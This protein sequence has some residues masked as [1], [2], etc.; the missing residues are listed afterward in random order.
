MKLFKAHKF[1]SGVL[2]LSLGLGLISSNAYADSQNAPLPLEGYELDVG[3]SPAPPF[4]MIDSHFQDLAGI[5]V[6]IIRELQRR[7]GFKLKNNRFHIMGFGDLLDLAAKGKMDISGAGISLSAKR[8]KIFTQSPATFRSHSVVV[9]PTSSTI[10]GR[11]DLPGKTLAAENGTDATDLVS[12]DMAAL[13]D[14]KHEATTF[15]T[16]Y[17]VAAGH[18]DALITEA[19]MAQEVVDDWA[20]GKLKIAYHIPDSDN[21]MGLMFKKDT[22]ASKV[23]YDTFVQMREDGTIQK[24]VHNY[25]PNYE[26]PDDLLPTSVRLAKQKQAKKQ[27]AM[28]LAQTGLNSQ[29]IIEPEGVSTAANTQINSY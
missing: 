19:P 1:L 9:V 23:L 21:D 20:R 17:S 3:V 24:I 6:D 13:I 18:S 8:E 5:D 4:V 2:A 29:N 16:F 7:T 14:I 11:S 10:K 27:E 12:E 28:K 25:L 22:A 15:M 26:F